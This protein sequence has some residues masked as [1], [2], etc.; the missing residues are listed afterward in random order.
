MPKLC[1]EGELA[2]EL[3]GQPFRVIAS[4]DKI[5]VS[6]LRWETLLSVANHLRQAFTQTSMAPYP[7][8]S[9]TDCPIEI[10]SRGR[11]LAELGPGIQ[12]G[13]LRLFGLP[14]MRLHPLAIAWTLVRR[15]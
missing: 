7:L 8:A 15:S 11:K 9:L 6:A 14:P 13:L 1:V 10:Q 3:N 12:G 2:C 5:V 4:T